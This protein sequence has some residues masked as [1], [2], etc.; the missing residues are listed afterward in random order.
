MANGGSNENLPLC[1][2]EVGRPSSAGANQLAESRSLVLDCKRRGGRKDGTPGGL[3]VF[4]R[5]GDE[6]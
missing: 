5:E 1:S 2:G 6:L 4:F 3:S